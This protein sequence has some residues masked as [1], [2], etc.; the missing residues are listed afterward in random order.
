MGN[1]YFSIKAYI[2]KFFRI[3]AKRISPVL[4]MFERRLVSRYS[5]LPLKHQPVFII[6]AP[7]T[8]STIL[9]Q[10]ITNELD[11]LYVDNLACS[12]RNNLFFGIWLSRKVFKS[13]PHDNF[14]SEHGNTSRHG[15][16]APS[17]CGAF[18]Y[19][20]MPKDR[21]FVDEN[22]IDEKALKEIRL[23]ITS[24]INYHDKPI[25]F[26]NLNAGLRMR[27]LSKIFPEAKFIWIKRDPRYV[28]QS[29]LKGREKVN[30]NLSKW[31][32]LMPR[33]YEILK[34]MTPIVQVVG[35]IYSIEQQ[36]YKDK[37]M[38]SIK[39]ILVLHY[40]D[41]NK[42]EAVLAKVHQFIGSDIPKKKN[43]VQA[44]IVIEEKDSYMGGVLSQLEGEIGILD[45]TDY[46]S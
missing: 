28:S 40:A 8:G 11:V 26:K 5:G 35:Q 30:A 38:F 31:W 39:N 19:R 6:G 42:L 18:W 41:L 27:V 17:E 32:S 33:N 2:V 36:I 24:V 22:D 9:Y 10:A 3:T 23:E 45:W 12:L 21:H 25:I 29:I 44:Q 34:K 14:K 7:R 20:W 16:H 1:K 46:T 15:G 37:S 43:P 13:E 4:S